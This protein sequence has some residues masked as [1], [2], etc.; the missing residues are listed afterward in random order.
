MLCVCSDYL[1]VNLPKVS[2][3]RL[4]S[5]CVAL[6]DNILGSSS[7]ALGDCG[8]SVA[9]DNFLIYFDFFV[10]LNR[11]NFLNLQYYSNDY[12]MLKIFYLTKDETVYP[13]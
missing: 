5:F 8:A 12:Q 7:F 10:L 11:E 3:Q 6:G 9:T 2:D 1:C 13:S 4:C